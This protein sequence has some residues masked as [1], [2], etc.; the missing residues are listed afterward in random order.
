M[1]ERGTETSCRRLRSILRCF[2]PSIL[3]GTEYHN[4]PYPCG[5]GRI[6]G[7]KSIPLLSH[8]HAPQRPIDLNGEQEVPCPIPE[9][10]REPLCEGNRET[11]FLPIDQRTRDVLIED[12]PQ[13]PFA[14]TVAHFE[15]AGKPP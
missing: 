2:Q 10:T 15:F 5:I 6:A 8:D 1:R 13:D 11:H 9:R 4:G 12:L 7:E 3:P 14:A